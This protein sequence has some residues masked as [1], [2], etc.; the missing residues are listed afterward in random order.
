MRSRTARGILT[1]VLVAGAFVP[2]EAQDPR[3]GNRLDAP[4]R[5][6]LS[7]LVDSAKAQG[8]PVEPLMEK[9]YQGLAMGA[10]GPR[11]VLAVR[12]LTFE[13]G[14]AHRV[15]GSVATTDEIKAAASAVHAGVPAVELGKMKKQSG[16]RRSLTLPFTVLADIVSRGVPVQTAAN[17]I[18]SLVGAGAR[19]RDISEFQRN[20]QVD[21]E[22]GAQPKAAAETRVKG[23][24]TVT[25]PGPRPEKR[26]Q[27]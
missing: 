4:T 2:A 15:L 26:E 3:I 21:I 22:K 10:D 7:A 6:A 20:V 17:A 8:I 14:N 1:V 25:T 5:K 24:V 12:S 9:V 13:M 18:R 19:D 23:A 27:E 16:L 11:I